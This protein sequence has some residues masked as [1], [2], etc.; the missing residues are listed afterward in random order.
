MNL[1]QIVWLDFDYKNKHYQG[2]AIAA[3]SLSNNCLLQAF[4]IYFDN[5]YNGTIRKQQDNWIPDNHI[6]E[7]LA[8]VI[9]GKLFAF[10]MPEL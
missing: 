3:F 4:E 10:L 9:S 7:G 6:E 1:K 2:E 8:K 5:E